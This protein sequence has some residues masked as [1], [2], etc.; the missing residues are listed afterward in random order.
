ML[1]VVQ[2]LAEARQNGDTP[3][4]GIIK[5]IELSLPPGAANELSLAPVELYLPKI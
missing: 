5:Q 1:A 2:R 4:G 3:E